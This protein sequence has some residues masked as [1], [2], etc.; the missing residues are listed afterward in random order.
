MIRDFLLSLI[1]A[2]LI[3]GC[4]SYSVREQFDKSV[5][6]YNEALRW[7]EWSN[8]S[9]YAEDLIREEFKARAAAAKDVRIVDYRI[10]SKNYDPEKREATV[11]VDIDY[12]RLFSPSVRTLHDTQKWVYFENKGTKGWK[13]IS[14]LPIFK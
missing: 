14:L 10:V 12:Y 6:A 9:R 1:M 2:V 11:E 8:A 13:L 5:E 4:S 3:A 7:F